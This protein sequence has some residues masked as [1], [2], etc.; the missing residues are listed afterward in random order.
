MP[1]R[2][3]SRQIYKTMRGKTVDMHK[4]V[5]ENEMTPAVGN[6][7][8]NARGDELGIGGKITKTRE[9][10]HK[11]LAPQKIVRNSTSSHEE[12]AQQNIEKE[13]VQRSRKV[14][15]DSN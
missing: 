10:T 5:K 4:L 15:N 3:Q 7:N 2:E 12:A 1:L 13:H 6:M 8:I 11:T 9:Q 14:R